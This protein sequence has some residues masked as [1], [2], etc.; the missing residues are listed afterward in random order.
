MIQL[1]VTKRDI[2]TTVTAS[3]YDCLQD[4]MDMR[5][6]VMELLDKVLYG[7]ESLRE[8]FSDGYTMMLLPASAF[9]LVDHYHKNVVLVVL[10]EDGL[11]YVSL[12]SCDLVY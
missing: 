4:D 6:A 11:P 3:V 7:P 2:W 5:G 9:E 1:E 12:T 8:A 10:D